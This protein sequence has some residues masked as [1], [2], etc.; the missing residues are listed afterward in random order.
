KELATD[1][2]TPL[3]MLLAL[4]VP[5]DHIS[6]AVLWR[7]EN[8]AL[9]TW[10]DEKFLQKVGH[11]FW[12]FEIFPRLTKAGEKSPPKT[13]D[14]PE[15]LDV[16]SVPRARRALAGTR[17]AVPPDSVKKALTIA[18]PSNQAVRPAYAKLDEGCSD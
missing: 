6:L 8:A 4:G 16:M 7:T 1:D 11:Y 2:L 10:R 12:K 15:A 18:A 3:K 9:T 13:V 14:A 5:L 17:K